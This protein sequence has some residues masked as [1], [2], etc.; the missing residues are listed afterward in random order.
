M[1]FMQSKNK[2][3][4][5]PL[6]VQDFL[7]GT[8]HMPPEQVGGYIRLL[9]HQ[10][11]KGPLPSD[12]KVLKR[13]SG[14]SVKNLDEILKKFVKKSSSSSENYINER[15]EKEW[16][17]Y[18]SFRLK[19]IENGQKGGRPI[20]QAFSVEEPKPNPNKTL[21]M[22]MSISPSLSPSLSKKGESDTPARADIISDLIGFIRRNVKKYYPEN[23]N[24]AQGELS[25]FQ[26]DHS[27][28]EESLA[29]DPNLKK[30]WDEFDA[31]ICRKYFDLPVQTEVEK[32]FDYYAARNFEINEKPISNW[33]AV[34]RT[35]LNNR[36][37]FKKAS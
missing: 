1:N 9:C 34:M 35:W 15:L 29:A 2:P 16:N 12:P 20:T 32:C 8:S 6:Y 33:R 37:R 22:S 19:Q 10:W 14:V 24:R 11:D 23:Y 4:S 13:I 7:L 18:E 3:P 36:D 17:K 31:R 26:H 30:K 21:S 27:V 5:F 28:S 25:K